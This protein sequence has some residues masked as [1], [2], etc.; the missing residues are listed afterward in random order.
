M[1]H[2]A[3]AGS[4]CTDGTANRIPYTRSSL[5]QVKF[6]LILRTQ[7]KMRCGH[8]TASVYEVLL[9]LA[10]LVLIMIDVARVS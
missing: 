5:L 1:K 10:I 8:K 6:E 9:L 3:D 4:C 2:Y 7:S